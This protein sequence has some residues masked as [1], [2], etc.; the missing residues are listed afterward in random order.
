MHE[1]I[2]ALSDTRREIL[3]HIKHRGGSTIAELADHLGISDEGTR[4]HLIHLERNGWV[5]RRDARD[6]AGRSGRPASV[7]VISESG[8]VFFPKRYEDLA[9]ALIDT[10]QAL[11]GPEAVEAALTRITDAKVEAWERRLAG[12]SLDERL[13]ALKSY[14]REGDEFV[15]VVKNG[16]V[17]IIERN[18]PY[19]MVAKS[20][21]ALC[22]TTVS[23][24]S[25]LLGVEV[26]RRKT[27]QKGDGCCEFELCMDRPVDSNRFH[28]ALEKNTT[29]TDDLDSS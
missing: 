29:S 7:Y 2:D 18:C 17:S 20:R 26:R 1:A 14:Y 24:L 21:S 15:S 9:V 27:F 6:T 12:K 8:E 11:Y 10:M 22:S 19:L 4:Q 13:E 25:R 3:L 5:A 23:V 28:F 16:T